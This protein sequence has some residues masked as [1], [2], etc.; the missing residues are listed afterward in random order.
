MM[1]NYSSCICCN[2]SYGIH[3]E[4]EKAKNVSRHNNNNDNDKAKEKKKTQVYNNNNKKLV[5][6]KKKKKINELQAKEK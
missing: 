3:G 1:L 5:R 6:K 4:I 2:N